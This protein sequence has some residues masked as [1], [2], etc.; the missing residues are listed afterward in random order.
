MAD[1]PNRTDTPPPLPNPP[2]SVKPSPEMQQKL[3][4]FRAQKEAKQDAGQLVDHREKKAENMAARVAQ[5]PPRAENAQRA[6]AGRQPQRAE[7][8]QRVEPGSQPPRAENA[9]R[10]EA[11][12]QPAR[13]ENAAQNPQRAE[14]AQ[15]VGA[16][17]QRAGENVRPNETGRNGSS[18]ESPGLRP[19]PEFQQKLDDFRAQK[20]ARQDAGLQVDHRE[21]KAENQAAREASRNAPAGEQTQRKDPAP[22]PQQRA[23]E[24]TKPTETADRNNSGEP[25]GLKPSPESQQKLDDFR[26]DKEARQDAGEAVDHR[27]KKAENAAARA[28]NDPARKA[29]TAALKPPEIKA[30]EAKA[31]EAKAPETKASETKA[32]EV[33]TPE[34]KA[35]VTSTPETKAAETKTATASDQG[36][37]SSGD[38]P[39]QG[40]PT[41]GD[42]RQVYTPK[43][44]DPS[45]ELRR[46]ADSGGRL[47]G[48]HFR[49]DAGSGSGPWFDE[50]FNHREG[51][52]V[53]QITDG[54]CVSAAGEMLSEGRFPQERLLAQL[55]DWSNPSALSNE[56]NERDGGGWK[57]GYFASPED[58]VRKAEDGPMAAVAQVPGGGHMVMLEPRGDGTFT[59][60]DPYDGGSYDVNS[61]WIEKYVSAGVW[62]E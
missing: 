26:A 14:N 3:D 59:V 23:G 40:P 35:P 47:Y 60:R 58:A 53:K 37:A 20:E 55:G 36:G 27:E 6:E 41:A 57:S 24:G 52:A 28:D 30:P 13:A 9:Q 51:G 16:P 42:D 15:R 50:G 8:A 44:L 29:D 56:M 12:R 45:A 46:E 7:N 21:K 25:T 31:P 32:P 43:H 17:Q 22:P 1:T 4:T 61:Q 54:S 39:L 33:K 2:E 18:P 62:Q 5:Q 19:S 48:E 38:T 11:G 49:H 10:A 34:A